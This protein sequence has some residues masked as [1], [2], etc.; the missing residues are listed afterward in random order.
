M[1]Q[2]W[3]FVFSHGTQSMDREEPISRVKI[4]HCLL[5]A[6]LRE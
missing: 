4:I 2:A 5:F 6:Q 1:I 3:K